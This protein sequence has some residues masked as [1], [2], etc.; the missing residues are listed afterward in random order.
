MIQGHGL[1]FRVVI[2]CD[3]FVHGR[4]LF[5][6]FSRCEIITD[7]A[8]AMLDYVCGSGITSKLTSYL[9][10][11]HWYGSTEPTSR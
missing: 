7:S 1:P 11:S 8:P 2:A 5:R 9:I 4:I 10:H 6:D 3:L